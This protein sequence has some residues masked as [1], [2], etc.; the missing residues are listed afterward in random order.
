MLIFEPSEELCQCHLK[1]F[2]FCRQ[3]ASAQIAAFLGGD[4]KSSAS[5]PPCL[6]GKLL[7]KAEHGEI[8]FVLHGTTVSKTNSSSFWALDVSV[9]QKKQDWN[10]ESGDCYQGH[11][12]KHFEASKLVICTDDSDLKLFR[13]C[14]AGATIP[15]CLSIMIYHWF[16]MIHLRLKDLME[17]SGAIEEE[18]RSEC[19]VSMSLSTPIKYHSQT[20]QTIVCKHLNN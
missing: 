10:R 14:I 7:G 12:L 1:R 8:Q 20:S 18:F 6:A 2:V 17:L 9:S 16:I 4:A 3:R 11:C 19:F 5:S 15:S 13:N